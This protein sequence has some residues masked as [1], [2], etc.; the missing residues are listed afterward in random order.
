LEN[1]GVGG[2]IILKYFFRKLDGGIGWIALAQE[3][4]RWPAL[5]NAVMNIQVP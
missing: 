2:R 4:G 1:P 5:V 3:R